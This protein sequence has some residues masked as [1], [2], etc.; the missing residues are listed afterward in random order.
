VPEE[1][2]K[3]GRLN[4]GL[5]CYELLR[6]HPLRA[7]VPVIM[8]TVLRIV[9]PAGAEYVPKEER[10]RLAITARNLMA[11][12]ALLEGRRPATS[13]RPKLF[14]SYCREDRQSLDEIK[15][16][17]VPASLRDP[18]DVWEDALIKSGLW[19][20]QIERHMRTASGVLF[21]VTL[22]FC[23]S[24]FIRDTELKYFLEAYRDRGTKIMWVNVGA[25]A[26]QLTPLIDFQ[27][28]N[29]PDRPLRKLSKPDREATLVDIAAKIVA[30]LRE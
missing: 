27:C 11:Y 8:L 10:E 7:H 14:I 12:L 25:S 15:R 30:E 26:V 20:P 9:C 29:D 1:V 18:I 5:R 4:A 28:L 13:P 3:A 16:A 23:A 2:V 24:S 22:D 19:R 17:I 21:L 6:A